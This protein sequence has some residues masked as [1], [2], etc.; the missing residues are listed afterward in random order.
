MVFILMA[1][2][3]QTGGQAQNIGIH[4]IGFGFLLR[5]MGSAARQIHCSS[6]LNYMHASPYTF[7]LLL[8]HE[9]HCG[10]RMD[11]TLEGGC[12]GVIMITA[13]RNGIEPS[14][15]CM[16]ACSLALS[17]LPTRQY[18]YGIFMDFGYTFNFNTWRYAIY[19]CVSLLCELVFW[20]WCM[21]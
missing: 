15:C 14:P 17:V 8:I 18:I 2:E 12:W 16:F 13:I 5:S 9:Q 6:S 20:I 1:K 3:G 7:I 21:E 19:D 11:G 10:W 4:S